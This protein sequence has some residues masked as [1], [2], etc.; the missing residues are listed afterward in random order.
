M[1]QSV[2]TVRPAGRMLAVQPRR[3]RR[4]ARAQAL[5]EMALIFPML[6]LLLLGSLDFAR[7][8]VTSLVLQGAAREGARLAADYT[9]TSSAVQTRVTNAATPLVVPTS[10][11]TSCVFSTPQTTPSTS[12]PPTGAIATRAAAN[13][14]QAVIVTVTLNVPFTTSFLTS[15][16]GLPSLDVT[17]SAQMIIL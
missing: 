15:W 9:Q 8:F 1:A 13:S 3:P 7:V 12:C 10:G 16:V 2:G 6:L 5:V 14:G 4:A 11:V 17:S